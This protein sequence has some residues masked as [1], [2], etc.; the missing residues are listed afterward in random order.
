M[1]YVA[2]FIIHALAFIEKPS[3]LTKTA[4]LRTKGD[5]F[6]LPCGVTEAI[7]LI[8]LSIFVMDLVTKV[9]S[10]IQTFLGL[11]TSMTHVH[12]VDVLF[13]NFLS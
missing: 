10:K 13:D 5:P 2:I 4:D 7:E 12:A 9:G 3:S 11:C 8:C 1:L 6:E